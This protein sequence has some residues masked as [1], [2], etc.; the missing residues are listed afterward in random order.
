[1]IARL[2]IACR[3]PAYWCACAVVVAHPLLHPFEGGAVDALVLA[4]TGFIASYRDSSS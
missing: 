4:A 3:R 1:M 2:C